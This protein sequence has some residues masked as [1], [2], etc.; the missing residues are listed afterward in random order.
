MS[1]I[2]IV[3]P[4][5]KHAS[6]APANLKGKKIRCKQCKEVF[7]AGGTGAAAATKPQAMD[8]E[9]DRN[10]YGVTTEN[11][12]A[13]CPFCAMA[14]DPP[15][16]RICLHCGYDLVKRRRVESKKTYET[17]PVDYLLW[18]LPTFGCFV[19]INAV[20]GVCVFCGIRMSGWLEGTLVEG[21]LPPECFTTW[22]GIM[23]IAAIWFQGKFIFKR[24][25]YNLHPPEKIKKAQTE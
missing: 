21:I 22:L 11:L 13:R 2:D 8:A 20:I 10:P 6:K 25:V 14:L 9:I 23:G 1:T 5:C 3:C 18:H 17:T 15:E 19:G 24:L 16:S 12:A 7:V 4:S